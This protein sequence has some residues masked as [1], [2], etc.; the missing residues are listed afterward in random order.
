MGLKDDLGRALGRRELD[1]M[2]KVVGLPE[3]RWVDGREYISRDWLEKEL[4][5]RRDETH[6]L[7]SAVVY[8]QILQL[9][10]GEE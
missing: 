8:E 2:R 3:H 5:R 4:T 1:K 9:I 7:A 10:A 6:F